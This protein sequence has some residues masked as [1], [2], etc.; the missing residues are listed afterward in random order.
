MDNMTRIPKTGKQARV[1][2][3]AP[4]LFG[5]MLFSFSRRAPAGQTTEHPFIAP[6][7][8]KSETC[9]T[10]HP[11]KKE[12]KAVHT[13]VGMGCENCHQATSE[14][15]KEKTAVTLI[16]TGGEL[17][18]MC[19][20]A[21]KDPVQHGPYKTGQCMVCH[22]PHASNFPKQTRAGTNTLCMSCHGASMPDVKVNADAQ[23]VWLLGGR[24]FDLASYEKAPKII[25][26]HSYKSAAPTV[27]HSVTGKNPRKPGAELNC[28]SCHDPHASK[29]EH[30]LHK[31]TESRNA[32]QN[33]CLDC[34]ADTNEQ[35]QDPPRQ[36][37]ADMRSGGCFDPVPLL[38]YSVLSRGYHRIPSLALGDIRGYCHKHRITSPYLR[39]H[40]IG[41]QQ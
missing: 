37:I 19:H 2:L 11:D 14:K 9:L 28:I 20:D 18:A 29:A 31:A 22:E 4:L 17:C 21:S 33:L 6:E 35:V 1:I 39:T 30:L 15:D 40:F 26:E 8:I 34:Q 24:T 41:G 5:V 23:T 7:D 27:S 13:A 38:P 25:A 16:A 36:S 3:V 12:G 10:C 32:A